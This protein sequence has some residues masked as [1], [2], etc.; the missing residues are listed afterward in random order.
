[1]KRIIIG[2]ALAASVALAT[3]TTLAVRA[4][5]GSP[6]TAVGAGLSHATNNVAACSAL[7]G[8][9]GLCTVAFSGDFFGPGGGPNFTGLFGDGKYSGK[10]TI[11]WSTYG[12]DGNPAGCANAY[13]TIT[14]T[15]N[16]GAGV[17]TTSVVEAHGSAVDQFCEQPGVNGFIFNRS[18]NL[19]GNVT[20][21]TG[22]YKLVEP[23]PQSVVFFVGTS[24][25]LPTVGMYEEDLELG[26]YLIV[27]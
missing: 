27:S 21:G 12:I 15:L 22:K 26:G 24:S 18:V 6:P 11:D 7:G 17:L 4:G 19:Q 16:G 13:G 8:G 3:G 14:Y 5:N 23:Y 10:V 1:M 9:G 20:K 25:A 2:V